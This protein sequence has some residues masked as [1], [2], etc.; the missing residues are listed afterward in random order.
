MLW[1]FLSES[2]YKTPLRNM[3]PQKF[4]FN[5]NIYFCFRVIIQK[6]VKRPN[7]TEELPSQVT[8][9]VGVRLKE[10]PWPDQ[11]S[12]VRLRCKESGPASPVLEILVWQLTA[13]C[14][15][16]IWYLRD[17]RK[18]C[19]MQGISLWKPFVCHMHATAHYQSTSS[20]KYG[21]NH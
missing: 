1:F 11:V 17:R 8:V 3:T 2:S 9:C 20:K 5:F 4:W 12:Q 13:S 10:S 18:C 19:R 15:C 21:I 14:G 7:P 16:D 6:A